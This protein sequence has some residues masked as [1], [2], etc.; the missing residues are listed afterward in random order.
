MAEKKFEDVVAKIIRVPHASL[1][2]ALAAF[3][4]DLP[5]VGKSSTNPHFKSKYADLAD[6]VAAVL[7]K[8]AEHGMA[9][10]TTPTFTVN[11][12]VLAYELRHESGQSVTGEWPL[13]DP[14][15]ASSQV[16]GSA[17]TY[18]KRYALSAVTGI[19][20]DDDDDGNKASE[21]R[22][23][24]RRAPIPSSTDAE[25]IRKAGSALR[26]AGTAQQVAAVWVD[27]EKSKLDTVPELVLIHDDL[28]SR[29][30]GDGTAWDPA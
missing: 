19:A 14:S 10:V 3:Q 30:S 20:P 25:R 26:A 24:P 27:I 16:L 9:W 11:G 12:F 1:T 2:E 17:V 15:T 29:F 21:G 4:A 23:A 28:L 22:S 18:G 13:P 8:L 6:I 7:P 5:R